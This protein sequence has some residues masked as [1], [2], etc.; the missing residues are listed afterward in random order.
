M[1]ANCLASCSCSFRWCHGAAGG[2]WAAA[3][4]ATAAGAATAG[5]GFAV[6]EG[7][8]M[9]VGG[10]G[11]SYAAYCS[12]GGNCRGTFNETNPQGSS[13]KYVSPT[14]FDQ[15]ENL[16]LLHNNA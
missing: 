15:L 12:S 14:D 10:A 8:A 6:V 11:G 13:I 1:V 16:G 7:V 5:T 3:G 4:L 9:V 2:A